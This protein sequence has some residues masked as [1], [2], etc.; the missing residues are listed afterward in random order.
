[1][2]NSMNDANN[3]YYL[4]GAIVCFLLFLLAA[5]AVKWYVPTAYLDVSLNNYVENN[6]QT[7]FLSYLALFVSLLGDKYVI[8]PTVLLTGLF[9]QQQKRFSL[10]FVTVVI[11]AMLLASFF[12]SAVAIPRPNLYFQMGK[13]AFPS[14]H[15]ALCSAYML[16]L[17]A[18][19][20]QQLKHYK[21]LVVVLAFMLIL[22]ESIS[23]IIL[24]IHWLTDIFGGLFLGSACAFIVVFHYNFKPVPIQ[25]LRGFFKVF[26]MIFALISLI[27]LSIYWNEM[28]MSTQL[29]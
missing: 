18:L 15:V 17:S 26:I 29:K 5:A 3:K 27:Y 22:L 24:G 4:M 13:Y 7:S 23:R 9:F 10:H 11:L 28:L 20:I 19:I 2:Q 16:F 8:I 12:K 14:R 1:M 6:L 25:N 21:W